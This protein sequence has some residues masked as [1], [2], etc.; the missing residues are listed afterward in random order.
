MIH[1]LRTGRNSRRSKVR[2]LAFRGD[3][4][5]PAKKK[6]KAAKSKRKW[7]AGV[8]TDSTHPPKG[9][10]TKSAS[11]IARVLAWRTVSPKGPA[12][13]MRMLNYYINRGG[14]GLGEERRSELHKAK[15]I[16]SEKI[17]KSRA[18]GG[19]GRG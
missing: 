1:P 17:E 16:L 9:L 15:A 2:I 7:V 3:D 11:T 12:S 19:H 18:R 8:D 14:K 13:G 4:E 5:M 10:F 6:K